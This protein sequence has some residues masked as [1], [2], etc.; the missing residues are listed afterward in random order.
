MA[1]KNDSNEQRDEG[2]LRAKDI[3]PPYGGDVTKAQRVQKAEEM[4]PAKDMPATGKPSQDQSEIPKF[5]L[6][7]KILAEQRK[8][9]ARRRKRPAA[10]ARE[11][12]KRI[13]TI[14][15]EPPFLSSTEQTGAE[16]TGHAIEQ[17]I[18]MLLEQDQI[19]AEIVA[20]DIEKLC[21]PRG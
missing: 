4:P 14:S 6:A 8:V 15:R 12:P 19:I 18:T 13:E 5:D 21:R 9:S 1:R 7:E 16:P 2:V 10:S 20:R 3:I 17:P 11:A